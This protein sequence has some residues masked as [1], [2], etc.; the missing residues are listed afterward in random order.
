MQ[1][2]SLIIT[3]RNI[4]N[5]SAKPSSLVFQNINLDIDVDRI[6][7]HDMVCSQFIYVIMY[8]DCNIIGLTPEHSKRNMHNWLEMTVLRFSGQ[9]LRLL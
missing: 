5:C 3:A 8:Y 1:F 2:K 6:I 7:L 9:V 4:V